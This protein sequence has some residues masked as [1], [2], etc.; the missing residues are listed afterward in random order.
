MKYCN[1]FFMELSRVI[2]TDEYAHLSR[3]A[4]WLFVVLNELEARFTNGK[5]Q[6]DFFFRTDA[7]LCQD[8]GFSINTLKK[9]KA[10]LRQTN[11]V[12]IGR[13]HWHYKETG[14]SDIRQPTTYQI[15]V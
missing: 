6:N 14:K 10:E 3:N 11:L 5:K 4:K 15:L 12:K 13:G 7:E 9:A 2:F 8:C 1:R